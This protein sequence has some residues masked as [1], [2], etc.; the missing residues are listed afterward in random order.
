MDPG[1]ISTHL[2]RATAEAR[3]RL[4]G[5]TVGIIKAYLGGAP[6]NVVNK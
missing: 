5:I 3:A 1:I 6:V 2:A 4:A